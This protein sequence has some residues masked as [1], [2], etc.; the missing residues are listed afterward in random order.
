MDDKKD[1][2]FWVLLATI[3]GSG[4][5]F[6][7][8]TV[9]YV[10]LPAIQADLD[11][12]G[13]QLQWVF[14][15]YLVF[16]AALILVGGSLGDH[17]GRRK[18]FGIGIA[19]FTLASAWSGLAPNVNQLI[20]ARAVQGVG[21]AL[22]T[23]GSL[24]IISAYFT[25][26]T[27]RGKAI[28]TWSALTTIVF[29][30]GP[31]IGGL[32]IKYVS[33]RWLFFLNVPLAII[34]LIVLYSKVPESRDEQISKQLDWLG[35]IAATL[36]LAGISYGLIESANLGLSHPVVL[37]TVGVGII[38]LIGFIIAESRGAHPM[39]PLDLFHSKT[40]SGV[41]IL[42]CLLYGALGWFS[43][44]IP[45]NL[46][47]VQGYE[48]EQFGFAIVPFAV[49]MVFISPWAG[50]LVGRVGAKL[51]LVV[52]PAIV[53]VG[54]YLMAVSGIGG[55][56]WTTYFPSIAAIGLGMGITV[57]PLSTTVMGAV[58]SSQAGVASGINNA[59][60]R[61]ASLLI[62]AIFGIFA[63]S[64]FGSGLS[65]RLDLLELSPDVRAAMDAQVNR[66]AGAQAPEDAAPEVQSAIQQSVKEAFIDSFRNTFLWATGLAIASS[67][68]A[69]LMVEGKQPEEESAG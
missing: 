66:L 52:G 45:L 16:L 7:D 38:F 33:W 8:G 11:A 5:A 19:L 60:A 46:I 39:M 56:Y 59:V 12:T 22:L 63:F 47:Q 1:V 64:Y 28:G 25:D 15:S 34:V 23:P 67:L 21:G 51:P 55:D 36:G 44:Y 65:Q 50:G 69:Y 40:F 32:L 61:T 18:I 29:I 54:F 43:F 9:V 10:A 24:A 14:E 3:L 49:I 58:T 20:L 26:I 48:P 42:T 6:L 53:S 57:A 68:T 13:T 17:Y 4:M 37:S 31:V 30:I 41:N 35:A 2:G 62:V 27:A